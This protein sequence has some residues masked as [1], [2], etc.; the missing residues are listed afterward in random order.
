DRVA[1]LAVHDYMATN[2]GRSERGEQLFRNVVLKNPNI[3]MVLC[4]HNYNSNRA[5]DEIDDN[6]DG[7]ADRTVYQIMANYQYASNG[8]NGCIRF[9]ECDVAGGTITHRTYS[10]YTASFGSDYEDGKIYDEF[11]Y[12]DSFVTPFDFS[13][14]K[15]KAESD[16]EVGTVVY[17]SDL[18]LAPTA[19][20]ERLTLPVTYQNQ[21]ETGSTYRGIGVYDRFFSLD[22]A[23]AFSNPK[24][25]TYVVTSYTGSSGH[26]IKQVIKGS[27]L[28]DA[29]VQVPIPQNGAVIAIPSSANVAADELT[30]GRH[31]ILTKMRELATPSALYATN[32][33]VPSWGASFNISD[34]NRTAGNG[35]WILYDSRNTSSPSH[36]QSMLFA[37]S[38]TGNGT[39]QLTACNT[40]IGR[41]KSL[42]TPSGGFVLAVNVAGGTASWIRSLREHFRVG[43]A[44]NLNNHTP[45]TAPQHKSTNLLAPSVGS[46]TRESTIVVESSGSSHVFYNTD[47]LYPK[48]DYTYPSALT[49]DPTSSVL[50]YDYM[51]EKGLSVSI[52]LIFQ[53]NRSITVQP[54]FEGGSVSEKSG[55]LEGDGV[56]RAG[57]IDISAMNIPTD[58]VNAD[59]TVT[60]KKI[61]IYA[62]GTANKK[63]YLHSLAVTTDRSPVGDAVIAQSM[64][65]T[66]DN[67][68]VTTSSEAGGYV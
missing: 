68:T 23:D 59:G 7:K 45:G 4:G 40:E 31:V 43:L 47:G 36:D 60:L 34:I 32:I 66:G 16:P 26:T 27:S 64:P 12:R 18:S 53:N 61:R 25:L 38:P 35:E 15:P 55:D 65:L 1:I 28:S 19:T 42:A 3:R 8:G 52:I 17:S 48:A 14:P 63:L 49:V 41:S 13:D 54:Y 10:P 50:Y 11:G 37:F 9:M 56:R 20:K 46:Y 67:I 2:G 24:S 62:S 44:V 57:K 29:A 39:Y 6:G 30:I 21:A 22:A 5:V 33:T 51:V 58:C